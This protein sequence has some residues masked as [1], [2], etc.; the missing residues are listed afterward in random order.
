[1]FKTPLVVELEDIV[2]VVGMKPMEQWS[3][4]Q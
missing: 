4:E 1:M 3:E 2:A